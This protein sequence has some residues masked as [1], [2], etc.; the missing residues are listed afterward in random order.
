MTMAASI[1]GQPAT[2]TDHPMTRGGNITAG[3]TLVGLGVTCLA[4]T[5]GW[6]SWAVVGSVWPL[7]LIVPGMALLLL[8]GDRSKV[9][10]G[11]LLIGLGLVFF[12]TSTGL[13]PPGS[14]G[15]IWPLFLIIPGVALIVGRGR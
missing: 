9:L 4:T 8:G 13:L 12:S 15:Y 1:N 10:G 3:L 5:L 11:V 6:V 7:C 2:N 14:W